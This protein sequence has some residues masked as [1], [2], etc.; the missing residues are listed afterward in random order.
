MLKFFKNDKIQI[1]I[2]MVE[3]KFVKYKLEQYLYKYNYYA[4]YLTIPYII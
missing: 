1:E 4:G 3:G 2:G